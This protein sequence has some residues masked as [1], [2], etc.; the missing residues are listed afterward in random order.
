[1]CRVLYVGADSRLPVIPWDERNPRFNVSVD[2]PG[3]EIA[4]R[5]FS[6]PW[7]C[8]VGAHENC[9]CGF[10]HTD[11]CEDADRKN[12]LD[13]FQRLIEHL[14][15]A[16]D[17]HG[18]VELFA[19]YSGEEQLPCKKKARITLSELTADILDTVDGCSGN[20]IFLSIDFDT[21]P[22]T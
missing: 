21:R 5:H 6:K 10:T 1:M 13:S 8:Y 14:K 4:R 22:Q 11:P 2:D 3:I 15:I 12:S 7:L 18:S 16:I 9:G 19:C 17:R 20:N